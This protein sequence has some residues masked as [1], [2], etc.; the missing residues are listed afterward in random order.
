MCTYEVFLPSHPSAVVHLDADE[1]F[2]SVRQPGR[3]PFDRRGVAGAIYSE[4]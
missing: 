4:Y 2:S 1:D 3:E